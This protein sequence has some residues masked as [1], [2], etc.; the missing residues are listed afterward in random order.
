MAYDYSFGPGIALDPVTLQTAPGSAG[1][2][3]LGA[4]DTNPLTVQI[5]DVEVTE[6]Q[7]GSDAIVQ[8]FRAEHGS[9]WLHFPG[10]TPYRVDSFAGVVEVTSEARDAATEA[11]DNAAEIAGRTMQLKGNASAGV[12]FWGTFTEGSAPDASDGVQVGDL[13]V[14]LP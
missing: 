12:S 11:A 5:G 8:G 14:L 7:T 4:D 2:A 3:S 1:F 10:I 13:G 9:V 6:I